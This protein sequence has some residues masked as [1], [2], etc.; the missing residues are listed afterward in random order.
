[1]GACLTG[2]LWLVGMFYGGAIVW[3]VFLW[4]GSNCN[5]GVNIEDSV[6]ISMSG[7]SLGEQN[8]E[9]SNFKDDKS[10][11]SSWQYG[12]FITTKFILAAGS[13]VYF[14]LFCW[15]CVR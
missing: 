1:M 12:I 8:A 2:G 9:I 14:G 4:T 6:D 5:Y 10:Q 13:S 7:D 15:I 11:Y 3:F